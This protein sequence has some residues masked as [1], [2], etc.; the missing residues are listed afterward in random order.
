MG[1]MGRRAR[2]KELNSKINHYEKIIKHRTIYSIAI[3]VCCIAEA[4]TLF[5]LVN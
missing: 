2:N 5:V 1:K 3:T 4:I